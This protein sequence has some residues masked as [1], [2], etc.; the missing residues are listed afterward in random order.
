MI[1]MSNIYEKTESDYRDISAKLRS[2]G[3]TVSVSFE[4]YLANRI[5]D[6]SK[7]LKIYKEK[8]NAK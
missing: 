2:N 7:A 5:H 3:R 4:E 8:A 6:I 1:A